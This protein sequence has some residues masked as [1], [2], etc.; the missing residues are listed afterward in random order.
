M[1]SKRLT[2]LS[3]N[4]EPSEDLS[5]TNGYEKNI[6][7]ITETSKKS[8]LSKSSLSLD[9]SRENDDEFIIKERTKE[10]SEA[11][12]S[13]INAVGEDANRQGLLKT[14]ERAAKAILHFTKG[15]NENVKDVIQDAVFDEDTDDLVIVKDIEMFSLC[16]H[17]MVPFMGKVSVGYLPNKKVLGLS[18]IARF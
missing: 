9:Q 6:N 15:Y 10:I 11:Y 5:Q 3:R 7:G 12:L 18:K 1:E 14:P 2:F 8:I 4:S 17:H 13:I 16:E